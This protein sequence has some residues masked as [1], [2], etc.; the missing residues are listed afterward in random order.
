MKYIGKYKNFE[1]NIIGEDDVD[2]IITKI[3]ENFPKE[4]V[5]LKINDESDETD[6]ETSL[7]DMICWFEDKFNREILDE[8]DIINKLR[9]YYHI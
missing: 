5:E 1:S 9:E 4:E 3:T 8:D 6:I 7:I 2:F